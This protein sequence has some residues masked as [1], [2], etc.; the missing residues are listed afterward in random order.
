M[1]C[2]TPKAT[3]DQKAEASLSDRERVER[4]FRALEKL[5]FTDPDKLDVALEEFVDQ[6]KDISV[7][8]ALAPSER[9][10]FYSE[11]QSANSRYF[12]EL[13]CDFDFS[14]NHLRK[15]ASSC[16]ERIDRF[17]DCYLEQVIQLR[18]V[19]RP[20]G[21]FGIMVMMYGYQAL[22]KAMPKGQSS[23]ESRIKA[24]GEFNTK[25]I[26][27]AVSYFDD[28]G[29]LFS[30]KNLKEIVKVLKPI[31]KNSKDIESQLFKFVHY[32][33]QCKWLNTLISKNQK[34]GV[35]VSP[36]ALGYSKNQCKFLQSQ[37]K[38]LESINRGQAESP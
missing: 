30:E 1:S 12:T 6:Q 13:L 26:E 21:N 3:V 9:E 34:L 15:V 29:K 22:D 32:S 18:G 10:K 23:K 19:P 36:S 27:L 25:L 2:T 38:Q 14:K 35:K 5:K 7:V 31:D 11:M 33:L 8:C 37:T 16:S 17:S 4:F 28:E 20:E 24:F